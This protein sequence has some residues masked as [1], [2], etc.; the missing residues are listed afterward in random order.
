MLD[1][2]GGVQWRGSR[3]TLARRRR[4]ARRTW[5]AGASEGGR[6]RCGNMRGARLC[7]RRT[8]MKWSWPTVLCRGEGKEMEMME[9]NLGLV[10]NLLGL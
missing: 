4:V 5:V 6:R 9:I 7:G 10:S 8:V 1:D 3:R 2:G